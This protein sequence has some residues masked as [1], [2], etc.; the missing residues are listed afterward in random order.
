[1]QHVGKLKVL[2]LSGCRLTAEDLGAL[3]ERE[4]K[5]EHVVHLCYDPEYNLSIRFIVNR[6][7]EHEKRGLHKNSVEKNVNVL[8]SAP[9][10]VENFCK[11]IPEREPRYCK[12]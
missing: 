1:M 12:V 5:S 11:E 7:E 10:F 4:R 2:K 3:G 6:S 8:H 9:E